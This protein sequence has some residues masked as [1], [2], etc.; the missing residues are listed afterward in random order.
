VALP[1]DEY[2]AKVLGE[3]DARKTGDLSEYCIKS[4]SEYDDAV[5]QWFWKGYIQRGKIHLVD[6]S[7]SSGK[8]RFM[9][10]TAA[11]AQNGCFPFDEA[12]APYQVDPP[13]TLYFSSEDEPGELKLVYK[14]CGGNPDWLFPYSPADYD[15]IEFNNEGLERLE[16]MINA[17]NIGLVVIDPILEF[18]PS[19][20]QNQSDN[21]NI[22]KFLSNLR[23]VIARTNVACMAVRHWAL[24]TVGKSF[25]NLAAGGG[26][27]RSGARGQSVIF[28]HPKSTENFLQ[29]LVIPARGSLLVTY[30][31]PFCMEVRE[32]ITT[33][34]RPENVDWD[35]YCEKYPVLQEQFGKPKA[36]IAEGTRGPVSETLQETAQAILDVLNDQPGNK[37]YTKDIRQALIDLGHA[38]RTIYRAKDALE[39]SGQIVDN[40]G[41]WTLNATYD[42][43]ENDGPDP[44]GGQ[45]YWQDL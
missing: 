21:K 38:Q 23:P 40:R 31:K 17:M 5:V 1:F 43:F 27:W 12:G 29:I 2:L 20:I 19:A 6:A 33:F 35:A 9:L 30:G 16:K 36:K 7:A 8:T 14:Q 34:V 4:A 24:N 11:C 25:E 13:R 22:T 39:A 32:N 18:G 15:Y 28:K 37:M 26:A 3:W 44:D 42:P 41:M 45:Q 10:A